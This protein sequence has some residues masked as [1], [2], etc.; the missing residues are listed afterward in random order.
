MYF[1]LKFEEKDDILVVTGQGEL[2]VYHSLNF[3]EE[4]MVRINE[5]TERYIILNFQE[6]P[7][8]DSS[9]LGAV[10]SLLKDIHKHHKEIALCGM[11]RDVSNIFKMT[12]TDKIVTIYPDLDQAITNIK[13]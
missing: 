2:D 12:Q 7:Y 8:V 13:K 1:K 4:A 11:N 9:G 10:I 5:K 3:K 6:I